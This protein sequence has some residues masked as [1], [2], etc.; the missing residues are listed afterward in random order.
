MSKVFVLASPEATK[1]ALK[2]ANDW[3]NEVNQKTFN[4]SSCNLAVA[5]FIL[6]EKG[7]TMFEVNAKY[8]IN[9]RAKIR[10]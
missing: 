4:D 3:S 2:R 7:F 10:K 1:A 6:N 9:T 5:E 8:P